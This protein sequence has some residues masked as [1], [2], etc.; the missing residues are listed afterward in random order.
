MPMD[1]YS[2]G[3]DGKAGIRGRVVSKNRQIIGNA[4][5]SG[6]IAGLGKAFTPQRVQPLSLNPSGITQFQYPSPEMV[7]GQSIGGGVNGAAEQLASY[8][9]EMARNIFPI[10]VAMRAGKSTSS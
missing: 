5:L 7:A 2:V 3:E 8:Y 6:F 10:V 4:L 1:A 9:L